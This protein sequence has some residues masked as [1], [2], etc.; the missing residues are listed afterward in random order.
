MPQITTV[1]GKCVTLKVNAPYAA[2]N[3]LEDAD[4]LQDLWTRVKAAGLTMGINPGDS[5]L[6]T[7]I[8]KPAA[9][10]I[11]MKWGDF[12]LG[13]LGKEG[14]APAEVIPFF[15]ELLKIF[16]GLDWTDYDTWEG[17]VCVDVK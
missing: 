11:Q 16:E 14:P 13:K 9:E 12:D 2:R 15:D 8:G 4:G 5:D 6:V 10:S 1:Q 3:I 17:V 7:F